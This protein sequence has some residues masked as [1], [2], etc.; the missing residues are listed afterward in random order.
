MPLIAYTPKIFTAAHMRVI[1][2]ATD[3]AASYRAQ[4][5]DLT[6]RQLYYQFVARGLIANKDT[7]YKRLGGILNDA[8]MAGEFDWDYI[9]DRTRNV[10]GGDGDATD[11]QQVI[12]QYA[13]TM[14]LWEGQPQ[15]VE[16]W[17]EKDA[18]VGVIGRAAGGLRTP[19][20]SCRGYTSVSEI[21]AAAHHRIAGYF[22]E[23]VEKVTIL[24]LG[25][26]DPS[27]IDMTRDITER[28]ITFLEGDGYD[29]YD[30]DRFEVRRIALNMNQVRQYN[31]PPNPAKITDPRARGYLRT[32]GQV[33][34]ELDALDPTVLNTLISG[35]IRSRIDPEIWNARRKLELHGQATLRAVRDHYGDI[36]TWLDDR[37]LLPEPVVPTDLD[38]PTQ[39]D[40]LTDPDA[41]VIGDDEE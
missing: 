13:Y 26:H 39:D 25:D 30:T 19:Y 34:W 3:I 35:E 32:F 40:D 23:G 7:E 8:R 14:A 16:V 17:V 31:P 38:A 15:R 6:L 22:D 18:L 9:T 20:F 24:H 41:T 28:L 4:G 1:E 33:S 21:W 12:D 36:I 29:G 37:G 2:Q 10:R 27:G 5:Y 11:P